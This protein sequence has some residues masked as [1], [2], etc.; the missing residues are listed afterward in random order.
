M[1]AGMAKY[2]A[3][4]AGMENALES[5]RIYGASKEDPVERYFRDAP[6]TSCSE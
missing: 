4:E 5:K 3:S 2:V 6:P 1:E